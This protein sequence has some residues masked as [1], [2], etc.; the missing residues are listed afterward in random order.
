MKLHLY[1]LN[2]I[3][4]PYKEYYTISDLDVLG[5]KVEIIECPLYLEDLVT[6]IV[7][8][9]SVKISQL[10]DICA[11]VNTKGPYSEDDLKAIILYLIYGDCSIGE[12]IG[13]T[14]DLMDTILD[15]YIGSIPNSIS[16][17]KIV[18]KEQFGQVPTMYTDY[19]DYR[20]MLEEIFRV[21]YYQ[22]RIYIY[23]N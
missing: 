22:D 18:L 4:K 2:N 19:I 9:P 14:I 20:R 5:Y 1:N 16:S 15:L 21:H 12:N 13:P 6:Y 7:R 11:I 17:I 10:E 8:E 23:M 3:D